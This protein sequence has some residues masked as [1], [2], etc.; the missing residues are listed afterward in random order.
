MASLTFLNSPIASASGVVAG[1]TE[2]TQ[3]MNNIELVASNVKEAEQ[4]SNQL[5]QIANQI[6]AYQN[7]V[8]NTLN[9]PNQIW[10]NADGLLQ[11]LVGVV[12]QGQAL[13]FS[14]TNINSLFLNAANLQSNEFTSEQGALNAIEAQSQSAQGR[15]QAI[16]AGNQ[17]AMAQVQQMRKMRALQMA[18]MQAQ[19]AYM[20]AQTQQ[21]A[22]DDMITQQTLNFTVTP[23]DT[24]SAPQVGQ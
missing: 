12:N 2:P 4:I 24:R 19:A 20:D 11:Q 14:A 9:I 21:K 15:M 1:A 8:T 18:Q 17:I 7:M 22:N 10:Q 23:M 6:Q 3:I 5:T 13:A 16:Q